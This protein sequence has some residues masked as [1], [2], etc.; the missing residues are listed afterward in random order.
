MVLFGLFGVFGVASLDTQKTILR[1]I[2]ALVPGAPVLL[3][4][5]RLVLWIR[6]ERSDPG[7][8]AQDN[9]SRGRKGPTPWVGFGPRGQIST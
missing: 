7:A 6:I 8:P 4:T 9:F 2:P 1:E 5:K 3:G